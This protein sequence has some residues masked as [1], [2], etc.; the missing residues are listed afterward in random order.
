MMKN[1]PIILF[2][3]FFS[4][5]SY[6][7]TVL[8]VNGQTF[9]SSVT[10]N[11]NA[12]N[13][14]R[15]SV[16]TLTFTNNLFNTVNAS[17]YQLCAGDETVLGTNNNLDGA[18][19]TGN[20]FI[21]NGTDPTATMHALFT[22]YN[23]NVVIKYNY[24]YRS[25]YGMPRKSSGMHN[26]SGGIAYNILMDPVA[27][28]LVKGMNDVNIFNNTFYSTKSTSDTWHGLIDVYINNDEGQNAPSTNTKIFNNIFYTKK[29]RVNIYVYENADLTGF[30]SDYNIFYCESGVPRFEIA[31]ITYSFAQWQSMGYDQHSVIMN[32]NFI[33]T[34]SLVPATRLDYGKDLGS[35]WI[36]GLATGAVWGTTSPATADQ[37]GTW[38]VGAR[39]YAS[40][41]IPVTSITVTG[42]GGSSSITT[43]K[44]TLQLAADVLPVN[45]SDRAVIWSITNG[46]GQATI[47]P[48]GLVTASASGTVTAKATAHDGSGKSGTLVI[49]ITNQ[50]INV[51]GIT[52]TGAGGATTITTDKGTLQLNATV[53]PANATNKTI[54]WSVT[55]VSGQA[56]INASSGLITAVANGTVTARAT[57][58]DGSGVY[59]SLIITI[60]NQAILVSGITVTGAGGSTTIIVHNG[61]LQ[62]TA[63]ILPVN[64]I[65][66]IVTW[67]IS[68][69]TGQA[70][71]SSSG[72]VSA[73]SDGTVTAI[74]TANDGSGVT[75]SLVITIS[76]QTTP[77]TSITV[78][79]AGGATAISTDNGTLQLTATILP[80][81]ASNKNILWSVTNGTGQATI[82]GTGLVTAVAD[83][84]VTARAT[85]QD[86]SGVYGSLL[87]TI[88]N[89]QVPVTGITVTGAGGASIITTDNGTLQLSAAIVPLS[90]TNQT[91]S[92]SIVN[93]TG[94]ATIN[95]SGLVTAVADGTVT[96]VA[97]ATDGSGITGTLIINI[98]SQ[99]IAVTG[100]T[101]TGAGGA[102]TITADNGTLQLSATV[103]PANATVKEVSWSVGGGTGGATISPTGL[104]T[105]VTNGTVIAMATATDGSG[106]TGI[107]SVAITSQVVPVASISVT[108]EGGATA[109][110]NDNATLQLYATVLPDFATVKSVAWSIE[111]ITGEATISSSGLV[112]A[113]SNGTVTAMA[114]ATDGSGISGTLLITISGQVIPVTEINVTG[115]GG[116]NTIPSINGTL[117]LNAEVLPENATISSVSWSVESVTG[118]ASISAD[119]LLSAIENGTVTAQA[120]ATDGSG[121]F[122]TMNISIFDGSE[123]L[124]SIVVTTDEIR[125]TFYADF[126]SWIADLYDFRGHL[127]Q[128]KIVESNILIFSRRSVSAGLYLVVLSKGEQL[129]VE[130]V[131]IP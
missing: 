126:V 34:I 102:S 119:G 16:T 61:S 101:V 84:T 67:S 79:G 125:I 35:E 24:L 38:Q 68:N 48:T 118:V 30:E 10:G 28:I 97:T 49:T 42:A 128:R 64:A 85:A 121:V 32:P 100:I 69:G 77:V 9:V 14:S 31:G 88:S 80:A 92:W 41:A 51:T 108:G 95:S 54:T 47:S 45:A 3:A 110:F 21:W 76:N 29:Q 58:T 111:N 87:L 131:M 73:V 25:P 91:V 86:G 40:S 82:S 66:Q 74:A 62:L 63:S 22:G 104:L 98:S 123:K 115:E 4:I 122:G 114:S 13:V 5:V 60:S 105:A 20:R 120:S 94:Q 2:L 19:I 50:A 27:G 129:Y 106:V 96:A 18:I 113:L 71:I 57:A 81:D 6:S 17:G 107:L 26:T 53:L 89:Q 90:A 116:V 130:K 37:N 109:I 8:N 99:I 112:T 117:Q 103:T 46:T 59:G 43:D 78:T 55:N 23:K 127:A 15:S 124:Y 72:L 39:I 7:Q 75:G 83:G 36:S 44:G 1:I 52:V 11:Y 65:N 12:Y 93:G 33:D 70:T 56:T